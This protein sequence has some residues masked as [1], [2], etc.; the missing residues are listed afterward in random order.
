[1]GEIIGKKLGIPAGRWFR[2]L[3]TSGHGGQAEPIVHGILE[4]R[5]MGKKTGP[6]TRKTDFTHEKRPGKTKQVF[7]DDSVSVTAII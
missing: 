6:H 2:D 5:V 3:K 1:V 4:K 7:L